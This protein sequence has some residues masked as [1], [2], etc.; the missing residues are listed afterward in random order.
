MTSAAR[1][2]PINNHYTSEKETF[3]SAVKRLMKAKFDNGGFGDLPVDHVVPRETEIMIQHLLQHWR[4]PRVAPPI[5]LDSVPT[6]AAPQTDKGTTSCGAGSGADESVFQRYH[7][8]IVASQL[9]FLIEPTSA[10][11]SMPEGVSAAE[12]IRTEFVERARFPLGIF[13]ASDEMLRRFAACRAAYHLSP[14]NPV[15]KEFVNWLV[16]HSLYQFF[17]L[18]TYCK[19]I[20]RYTEIHT[21]ALPQHI[22]DHQMRTLR[23]QFCVPDD[24]PVPPHL[25]RSL[26][27]MG[28]K[29]CASVFPKPTQRHSAMAVGN[30]EVRFVSR[31]DD[32][33]VFDRMRER[34]YLPIPLSELQS[35]KSWTEV[36]RHRALPSAE[37]YDR[38]CGPAESRERPAH[39]LENPEQYGC[40]PVDPSTADLDTF[41]RGIFADTFTDTSRF[42]N[43]TDRRRAVYTER[44]PDPSLLP[45]RPVASGQGRLGE[46]AFDSALWHEVD[47]R[48]RLFDGG[49][50]ND[51]RSF[52]LLGHSIESEEGEQY[53]TV[54]WTDATRRI[55]AEAKKSKQSTAQLS[56]ITAI[57]NKKERLKKLAGYAAKRRRD[58]ESMARFAACARRRMIEIDFCGRALRAANLYIAARA[59]THE[60]LH[61]GLL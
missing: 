42:A 53:A 40:M 32:D 52:L 41:A 50:P 16:D 20:E 7:E 24:K 58:A 29:R 60:E 25:M 61:T 23:A 17:L 8:N 27:C 15:V 59:Q 55:K 1:T 21:F 44:L 26:V 10:P 49:G 18:R 2:R 12:F 36:L 30:D 56:A 9:V 14:T 48:M 33:D 19:V 35:A 51:E 4:Y 28:C 6:A 31:T 3:L 34:N 5:K 47:R 46:L 11:T 43:P 13:H 45:L 37:V 39:M 57:A 54:K 22:A 38:Y